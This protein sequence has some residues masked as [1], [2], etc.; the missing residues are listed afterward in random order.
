MNGHHV[1]D[2]W[3][4]RIQL[5]ENNYINLSREFDTEAPPIVARFTDAIGK[6][7]RPKIYE[8]LRTDPFHPD[9]AIDVGQV[10]PANRVDRPLQPITAMIQ[11]PLTHA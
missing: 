4:A 7:L 8:M 10:Q 11:N 2:T 9:I 5:F 3:T 1:A 6:I